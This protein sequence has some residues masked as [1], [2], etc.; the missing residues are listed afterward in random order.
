M[1]KR[2]EISLVLAGAM[3]VSVALTGCGGSSSGSPESSAETETSGEVD[4]EVWNSNNGFQEVK[5]GGPEYNWLKELTGV[6]VW[7]PYVEWNGGQ[8]Y[9]EQLNL[10]IAAGEMPDMFLPV[11]GMEAELI[12]NGA[13]LDLTDLL[14]EKAP[15]LWES[16]PEEVWDIVRT[17]DPTGEGRIYMIPNVIDYPRMGGMIRQDCLDKL[18]LSMPTTQEEF[19]EVLRAFKEQDPNGNGQADEIPTGGRQSAKWMDQLFAMYGLAMWEGDP[20]WDIYDGELTYAAVTPNMRDALEFISQLYAEGLMDPET[21][22][23]D[24]A[25][26]EGKV[27]SDRVGVFYHWGQS[28]Y[29]F[30]IQMEQGTGVKPDWAILPP[31]SAEGYDAFYTTKRIAGIQWVVKNTDDQEKIDAVMKVLDAYGNKD[32][33]NDFWYGVEGMHHEVVDGK[34]VK[35]PEDKTTQENL[36]FLPTQDI[37]TV[38]S[39]VEQLENVKTEDTA[40][41]YDLSIRNMPILETYGKEIAGDGLPSSVYDG[42]PDILNK[43]LYVE[44]ASKIITGEYPIEKFDEFVERWYASGGEEVTQAAREWYA[45]KQQ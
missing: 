8:T 13:L 7:Q 44:Y 37:S 41:A 34:K 45:S 27:N 33:W 16:I 22:L 10:R 19:V 35:L 5:R 23:N 26:W 18:G 15:H 1:K 29:E 21:L 20:Q 2:R 42:Y 12:E 6:G 11:N 14:P 32:L 43:T 30:A 9:Q 28:A 24:K 39:V 38:D 4:L 36:I 25:G 3:A 40:W 17:Y 31:I